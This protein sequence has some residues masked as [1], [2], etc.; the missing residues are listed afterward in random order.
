MTRSSAHYED[1]ATN[2]LKPILWTEAEPRRLARDLD[3]IASFAPQLEYRAP[4]DD[5]LLHGGW[6]GQLRR[7]PFDRPQPHGLDELLGEDELCIILSYSAA[8]PVVPPVIYPTTPEPTIWEQ[9]QSAWHVAPGGSLCLLQSDNDW[10]PETSVA[11]LLAKASG[12]RIE[13]ALMKANVIE[14][15]SVNGI[16]SDASYDHLLVRALVQ[17]AGQAETDTEGAVDEQ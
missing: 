6:V 1:Q 9:T 5:G 17:E 10:Q 2:P 13:Y 11:E 4:A 12:W 8:H 15:M 14:Q 16:V 7:W 3:E